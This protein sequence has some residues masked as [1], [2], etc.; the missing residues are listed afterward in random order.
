MRPDVSDLDF[1]VGRLACQ[2]SVIQYLKKK[3]T[4][5]TSYFIYNE[6]EISRVL[7]LEINN[8]LLGTL[9]F[10]EENNIDLT[11]DMCM[12]LFP[13]C[14]ADTGC[15]KKTPKDDKEMHERRLAAFSYLRQC[16][17]KIENGSEILIFFYNDKIHLSL[18]YLKK[19]NVAINQQDLEKLKPKSN[20]GPKKNN[21]DTRSDL[22]VLLNRF[23]NDCLVIDQNQF[24]VL[25]S[26]IQSTENTDE[27][28]QLLHRPGLTQSQLNDILKPAEAPTKINE[29]VMPLIISTMHQQLADEPSPL[30]VS[31]YS[32]KN[33]VASATENTS[34][35]KTPR[36][37]SAYSETETSPT[38]T[39]LRSASI[40]ST[41]SKKDDILDCMPKTHSSKMALL[42]GAGLLAL[43]LVVIALSVF[44]LVVSHGSSLCA[45]LAHS[46]VFSGGHDVTKSLWIFV[47]AIIA[48]KGAHM[49]YHNWANVF[50][51][52]TPMPC[53]QSL[54][55]EPNAPIVPRN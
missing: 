14:V 49:I 35:P 38:Q 11:A 1:F 13:T 46:A 5:Y 7:K 3:A 41:R 42:Q 31:A 8:P 15:A 2:S 52:N 47:G 55:P 39:R 16:N 18:C 33:D 21:E 29:P 19:H 23:S 24:R 43:G 12:K 6:D 54:S 51:K 20:N 45:E 4:R 32:E 36:A 28:G 9:L 17:I 48:A 44:A 37:A 22:V 40:R 34:S 10:L 30:L 53:N 27:I 50:G 26:L 25:I